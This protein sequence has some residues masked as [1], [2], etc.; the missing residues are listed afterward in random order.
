MLQ[1]KPIAF[2]T[3]KAKKAD[4]TIARSV[5]TTI[6]SFGSDS[7]VPEDDEGNAGEEG[8]QEEDEEES[9]LSTEDLA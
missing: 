7:F 5:A 4:A 1:G 8:I 3:A 6:D 2:Y 9:G